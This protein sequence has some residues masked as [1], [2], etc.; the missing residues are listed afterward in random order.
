MASLHSPSRLNPS[1]SFLTLSEADPLFP[2]HP[3]YPSLSRGVIVMMANEKKEKRKDSP[4]QLTVP[5][6]PLTVL[7]LQP[8]VLTLSSADKSLVV[9]K[10]EKNTE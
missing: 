8:T 2:L 6:L 7:S 1:G 4:L 10:K 3:L 9:M 5:T